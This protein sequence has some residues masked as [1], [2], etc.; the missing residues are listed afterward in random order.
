[1]KVFLS[2]GLA[3]CLL[4]AA[5]PAASAHPR[6]HYRGGCGFHTI[7]DG[8]DSPGTTWRGEAD[9]VVVATFDEPRT[10]ARTAPVTV[11][12]ELYVDG[13]YVATP[14]VASGTGF[15]AG[16]A[17]PFEF[18]ADPD[19]IVTLC[20]VVTVGG[21]TH[22]DCGFS[23]GPPDPLLPPFVVDFLN[24]TFAFVSAVTDD[25][26]CAEFA[27]QDGGPV[28]QPPLDIRPEGDLYV[29]GEWFW[30]CP[31]YYV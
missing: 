1:M 7:S 26:V 17:V 29:G 30:D 21:E 13:M 28:D 12:C 27:A 23:G 15:A 2:T 24:A 18:T 11:A 8:S 16:Y 6:Y 14:V 5:A 9:A 20:D 3:A 31:P 19:S 22:V 4:A 25:T 10:P